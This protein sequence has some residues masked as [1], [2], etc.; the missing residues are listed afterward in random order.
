MTALN[1]NRIANYT[2]GIADNGLG[3]SLHARQIPRRDLPYDPVPTDG[4]GTQPRQ[5]G[6]LETKVGPGRGRELPHGLPPYV[7][8]IL[9]FGF[10]PLFRPTDP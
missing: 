5:A 4:R 8:D 2:W 3:E 10:L 1:L 9:D 6:R 7:Q